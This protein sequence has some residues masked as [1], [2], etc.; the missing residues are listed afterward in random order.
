ML[1]NDA[2]Q[3]RPGEKPA[4]AP[5][6]SQKSPRAQGQVN[7]KIPTLKRTSSRPGDTNAAGLADRNIDTTHIIHIHSRHSPPTRLDLATHVTKSTLQEPHGLTKIMRQK[8]KPL[9]RLAR[10]HPFGEG[11]E[12]ARSVP[13]LEQAT[14]QG[15]PPR[16]A[17]EDLQQ[18]SEQSQ[19]QDKSA[20]QKPPRAQGQANSEIQTLKRTRSR[21]DD[22]NTASLTDGNMDT[23]H[24]IIIHDRHSPPP[25]LDLITHAIKST[26]QQPHGPTKTIRQKPKLLTR[27]ARYHPFGEGHEQDR[28]A[29]ALEQ[30]TE[31][32]QLPQHATEDLKQNLEQSL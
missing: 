27:L 14:G 16:F 6:A 1:H 4:S 29:P 26:L 5:E 18:N 32:G 28:L 23:T 11:H 15:Q 8:S 25:R 22:T 10:Y 20:E 12:Q 9:T 3:Q 2:V 7:F 21:P 13:G 24:I 17:T 19:Q 31:P 30:G